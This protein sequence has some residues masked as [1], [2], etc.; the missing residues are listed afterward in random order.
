[1]LNSSSTKTAS[2]VDTHHAHDVHKTTEQRHFAAAHACLA[3]FVSSR[4]VRVTTTNQSTTCGGVLKVRTVMRRKTAKRGR[5]TA[6]DL[7]NVYTVERTR[8]SV[9][10]SIV[11]AALA[12]AL[13]SSAE[14]M[15]W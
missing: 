14:V 15:L 13:H 1:M 6:N 7:K 9:I 11:H 2:E 3:A 4:V 8:S 10:V 12:L 5:V